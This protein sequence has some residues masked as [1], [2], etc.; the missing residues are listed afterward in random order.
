M[1]ECPEAG[2]VAGRWRR[3][4][5]APSCPWLPVRIVLPSGLN[6]TDHTKPG[7]SIGWPMGWPVA[8][9]HSRAVLS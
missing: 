4:T 2:R 1:L 8:A 6:A 9:S 3:P 7:C 5:A